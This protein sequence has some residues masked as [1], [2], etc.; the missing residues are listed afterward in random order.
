[1]RGEVQDEIFFFHGKKDELN[2]SILNLDPTSATKIGKI[3]SIHVGMMDTDVRM[4][5][6]SHT[7]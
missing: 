4:A 1:M 3:E 6:L 7:N 2:L 5:K